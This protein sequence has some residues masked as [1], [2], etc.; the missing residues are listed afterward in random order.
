MTKNSLGEGGGE[1]GREGERRIGRRRGGERRIGRGRGG[2]RGRE[3]DREG[4][5]EEWNTENDHIYV[6][7]VPAL[8]L[9]ARV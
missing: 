9:E 7:V 2:Q 4:E 5:K 6:T 3:E 8:R 1:R